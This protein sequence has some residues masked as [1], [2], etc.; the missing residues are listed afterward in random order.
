M[1]A[2]PEPSIAL[3][4]RRDR[5]PDELDYRRVRAALADGRVLRIGPGAFATVDD[6]TALTPIAQHRMRVQEALERARH[7]VVLS[8]FA[9]AAHW[10]ID[11][12][13]A[14][15]AVI[16][17]RVERTGGGRSSGLFRRRSMGLP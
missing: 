11:I 17:T 1:P 6:W 7:P 2:R 10:G 9:A 14:W 4:R 3:V 12:L 8:R 13:G 5:L 16:D 15:P